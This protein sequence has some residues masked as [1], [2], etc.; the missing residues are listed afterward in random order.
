MN[1][2]PQQMFLLRNSLERQ[3]IPEHSFYILQ[4]EFLIAPGPWF[5]LEEFSIKCTAK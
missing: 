4:E 1:I 2:H 5:V 3:E